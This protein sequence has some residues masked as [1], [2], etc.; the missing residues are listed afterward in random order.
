MHE[1]IACA[2]IKQEYKTQYLSHGHCWAMVNVLSAISPE[3]SQMATFPR[4]EEWGD[5]QVL[6]SPHISSSS[7]PDTTT[8][9]LLFSV[10]YPFNTP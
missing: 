9:F 8:C 1:H 2:V 6:S 10:A 7:H 3:S 5:F 4:L